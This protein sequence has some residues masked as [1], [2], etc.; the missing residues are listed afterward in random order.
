MLVSWS[1]VECLSSNTFDRNLILLV[2]DPYAVKMSAWKLALFEIVAVRAVSGVPIDNM[3]SSL[4]IVQTNKEKSNPF[5]LHSQLLRKQLDAHQMLAC[6]RNKKSWA[7]SMCKNQINGKLWYSYL[8]K[9]NY[10]LNLGVRPISWRW[11]SMRSVTM[12]PGSSSR[13][14]PSCR[15]VACGLRAWA[16]SLRKRLS[17]PRDR[18]LS[19]WPSGRGPCKT[20]ALFQLLENFGS[21]V[22]HPKSKDVARS[23]LNV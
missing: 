20:R 14:S 11:G 6:V 5:I 1:S 8:I 4:I 22:E 16:E 10:Q 13:G 12:K 23:R 3:S 19:L 15:C 9:N 21:L 7:Y 18:T 2:V 17:W